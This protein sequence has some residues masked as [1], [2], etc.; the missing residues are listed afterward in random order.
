MSKLVRRLTSE[1]KFHIVL[2]T[3]TLIEQEPAAYCRRKG[4]Y[5]EDI[6]SWRK[7]CKRANTF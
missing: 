6:K 5:V 2:E 4:L 1:H 7:Q 3:S